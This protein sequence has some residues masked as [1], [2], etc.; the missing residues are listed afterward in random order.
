MLIVPGIVWF[1]LK[2]ALC[3]FAFIWVRATMPRF[4]Y[5]QLMRLGWKIFL[6]AVAALCGA[7]LLPMLSLSEVLHELS[8]PYRPQLFA[9]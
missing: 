3:L 4:R 7:A 5:D 2:I 1:A 8:R 9:G 6:P